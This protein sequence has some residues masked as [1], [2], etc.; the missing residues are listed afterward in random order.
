MSKVAVLIDSEFGLTEK[1]ARA[2]GFYYVPVLIEWNGKEMK[3]GVDA[4]LDFIYENLTVDVDFKTAAPTIGSIEAEYREALKENDHVYVVCISKHLSSTYNVFTL[5]AN[6]DEFK[7]KVTVYE[8]EFIGP[9]ALVH[10]EKLIEMSKAGATPEEFTALLDRQ[11]GNMF[12]WLF[13]GSLERVY[14]SGRLSKAQYMAGSLLKITP[15]MPIINGRIDQGGTVKTRSVEKAIK[16]VVENTV[17][18]YNE[19]HS[20]GINAK[21]LFASLGDPETNENTELLKQAFAEKGFNDVPVTWLP[22]AIVGH[23]GTGGIGAG[24]VVDF[25]EDK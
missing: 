19:L 3:S 20:Q 23:V 16:A 2:E 1:V 14:A 4:T 24:V 12:A 25:E 21:I 9:W 17:N 10:R 8:S 11:R 6:D 13:P 15:V 22:P 5:V 18:K 7:G